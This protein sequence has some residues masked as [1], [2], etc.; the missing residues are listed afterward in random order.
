[1]L[2]IR[3]LT[4]LIEHAGQ[5]ELHSHI[6]LVPLI[7][8]YLLY[9]GRG[10]HAAPGGTSLGGAL[11]L[12]AVAAGSW[13]AVVVWRSSLS[14]NDSL[15]LMALSFVAVVGAG[16]FLFLGNRWMA[17]RAF[18]FSFLLFMV[19]MPDVMANTLE[20][21]SMRASA[22]VSAWFLMMTGTPLL[23][24]GQVFTLPGIVLHVAQEC[25]GIR[26]S[27]VLVI[28]SLLASHMFLRG[29][30]RRALLVFFVIPLGIVRN[31]F[32]ILVISLMCVHIGPH[33]IDSPIHHR[34]G[35]LFF[36]LSLGPFF[37]FL[38][39]LRRGERQA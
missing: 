12:G 2:F 21:L 6:P 25:S 3:P 14:V 27:W 33:M 11:L 23:R 30:G 32:R 35:P 31:G 9:V 29:G 18:P 13:A 8:V 4:D 26:S 7:V 38:W 5:F 28:T 17:S 37:L 34:G 16:G 39:W 20:I 22:D 10:S 1:V 19:P 36:A 15:A 24:D